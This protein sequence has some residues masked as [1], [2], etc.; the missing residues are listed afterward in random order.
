MFGVKSLDAISFSVVRVGRRDD[1]DSS[2]T[3]HFKC[4][5]FAGGLE[6]DFCYS[7]GS[8]HAS[9]PNKADLVY[10]LLGDA[11]RVI[12]CDSIEEFAAEL[13]FRSSIAIEPYAACKRAKTFLVRVCGSAAGLERALGSEEYQEY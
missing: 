10:A 9:P 6:L 7:Q 11:E 2:G 1:D 4:R 12:Y 8:A 13:G 5:A 3:H